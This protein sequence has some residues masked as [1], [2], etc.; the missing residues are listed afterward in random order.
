MCTRSPGLIGLEV[1]DVQTS[2]VAAAAFRR[3]MWRYSLTA[4]D[5]ARFHCPAQEPSSLL[6][7]LLQERSWTQDEFGIDASTTLRVAL[8]VKPIEQL[9][10]GSITAALAATPPCSP[11][12]LGSPSRAPLPPL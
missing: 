12:H 1:R 9:I 2:S 3:L 8:M 7:A 6:E 5:V 11:S 10:P 4:N